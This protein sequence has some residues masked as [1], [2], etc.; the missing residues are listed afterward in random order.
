MTRQLPV[1]LLA[2][3]CVVYGGVA[4]VSAQ[5]RTPPSEGLQIRGYGTIGVVNFAA[6]DS[7]DAVLGTRSGPVIG[8]GAA[9]DLPLGG[10]FV[11]LG[12]WRFSKAGERAIVIGS[13]V[14]PLGIPLEV[15]IIP[16]EV[17]GG[18]RF[19][20]RQAPRVIPYAGGGYT[21]YGYKET[22]SFAATGEDVDERFHGYHLLGGVEFKIRRWLGLAGEVAWTAVPNAIGDAGV[23]AA[24]DETD[25]GG[26]SF[27][28]K[29]TVGQ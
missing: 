9:I 6:V 15:T 4:P 3:V 1:L 7:F 2:I 11:D 29:V 21:S 13:E 16:V 17:S 28:L 18:W 25:L 24:F 10:L 22:S 26:T 27:R 8:G 23:S 19:R 14:V 20:L 5:S 12:A